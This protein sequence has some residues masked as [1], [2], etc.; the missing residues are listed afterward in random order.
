MESETSPARKVMLVADP[1]RESAGALQYAL[2][3]VV[4]END[5]LILLHV[6]NPG[7]WRNTFSFLRRSSFPSNY[8]PNLE[9][10]GD[11]DFLEAMKQICEVA[12]P[13][14]RIRIEKMQTE[15][16][17]RDK[18]KGTAILAKSKMLG[19]DFIIIGQRRSLSTA[20]LGGRLKRS[21]SSGLKAIDTAEYLIENSTCTCV[22]VQKKG[23]NG[24][25]LLNTKTQRNFWLLA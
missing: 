10:G 14:I 2:S 6:E 23:Q 16:R 19:V 13:K 7:S 1:S 24:G 3:H 20:L 25:Y 4:L 12:Q 8:I 22:G 15:A 5:E 21:G 9:F 17:I 11:I 18:D